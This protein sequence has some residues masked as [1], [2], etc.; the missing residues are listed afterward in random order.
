MMYVHPNW[1]YTMVSIRG[2]VATSNL[3]GVFDV[4]SRVSISKVI[5][6]TP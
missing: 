5:A 1:N 2:I 3:M 4:M 6:V